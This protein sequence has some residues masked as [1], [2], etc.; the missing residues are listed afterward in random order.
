MPF[1]PTIC[2]FSMMLSNCVAHFIGVK[3]EVLADYTNFVANGNFDASL[4]PNFLWFSGP[5]YIIIITV[6]H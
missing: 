5:T 1:A 4:E 3:V 2:K 6:H